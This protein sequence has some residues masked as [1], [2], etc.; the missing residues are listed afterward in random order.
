SW[1][2][3]VCWID[4]NVPFAGSWLELNDWDRLRH[5]VHSGLTPWYVYRD[6]MRQIYLYFEAK[7]LREA[8]LEIAA[9]DKYRRAAKGESFS[10]TDFPV[11]ELGGPEA[12]REFVD[13]FDL[14][15]QTVPIYGLAEG[16][17]SRGGTNVEGN[18]VRNLA[19]N[20]DAFTCSIRS[21]PRVVSNSWRRYR[22]EYSPINAIDG[23]LDGETYWAP[24]KRTDLWLSVE[25]GRDVD[26]EKVVVALKLAPDQKK[27]WTNAALEFE[28]GSKIPIEL[29]LTEEPQI[30]EV[31]KTRS[32]F[33]KLTDL[34]EAFPLEYNGV[35]EIEVW[36][37]DAAATSPLTVRATARR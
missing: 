8:E 2:K 3:L 26:I 1:E 25:F 27:T 22:P 24:A 29:T 30:F 37:A 5:D 19:L 32:S 18:P 33:V 10:P 15:S 14:L 31:P 9:I 17:D 7:R 20:A 21:Y 28:D 35:K 4:L 12:Q 11:S 6:K 16:K 34:R 13:A 36:G 23:N